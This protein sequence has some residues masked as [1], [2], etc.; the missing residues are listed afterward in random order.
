MST[1]I[2]RHSKIIAPDP[3]EDRLG[4]RNASMAMVAAGGGFGL[5]LGAKLVVF[6][7]MAKADDQDI[8]RLETCAL[9]L[10]ASLQF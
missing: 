2:H 7:W 8:A 4:G 1:H 9:M 10:G 6:D 3:L 5:F